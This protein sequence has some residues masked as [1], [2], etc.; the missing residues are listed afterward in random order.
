MTAHG[1]PPL[2]ELDIA[3]RLYRLRRRRETQFGAIFGEP[4]W[5]ILLDLFIVAGRGKRISVTGLCAAAAVPPT[6]A[7]R[8][9]DKLAAQGALLL[10]ADAGD[11]RRVHVSLAP[12]MLARMGMLLRSFGQDLLR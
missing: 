10:E 5:D 4:A 6:T 9:V 8:W 1:R 11:R 12:D 2:S 3:I 7:L